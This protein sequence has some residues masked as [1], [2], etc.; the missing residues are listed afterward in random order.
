MSKPKRLHGFKSNSYPKECPACLGTRKYRGYLP[1]FTCGSKG[2]LVLD[3][4]IRRR[5]YRAK[6][7]HKKSLH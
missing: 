4:E 2:Y 5:V 1:C 6:N 7:P 3:D